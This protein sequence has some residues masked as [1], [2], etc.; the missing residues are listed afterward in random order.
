MKIQC[1][2]ENVGCKKAIEITE[3]GMLFVY[4]SKGDEIIGTAMYLNDVALYNIIKNVK[5]V[6]KERAISQIDKM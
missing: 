6:L 2:C 3:D 5:S 1:T 4:D